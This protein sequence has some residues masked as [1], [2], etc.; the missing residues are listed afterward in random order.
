MIGGANRIH[1]WSFF[2][3][4][5]TLASKIAAQFQNTETPLQASALLYLGAILLVISLIVNV[6]AQFAIRQ[7]VGGSRRPRIGFAL[8]LGRGG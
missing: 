5:D 1:Y 6:L 8:S 7:R 2:D 4:G 3:Y